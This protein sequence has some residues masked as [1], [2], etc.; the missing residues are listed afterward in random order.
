MQWSIKNFGNEALLRLFNSGVPNLVPLLQFK[1][2]RSCDYAS[3]NRLCAMFVEKMYLVNYQSCI[4]DL[5]FGTIVPC[6]K[7]ELVIGKSNA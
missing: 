6:S 7:K 4:S 5:F 1:R 3:N 2:I